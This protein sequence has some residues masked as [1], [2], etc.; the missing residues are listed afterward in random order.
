MV[1]VVVVIM[2]GIVVVV[3]VGIVVGI[4]VVVVVVVVMVV[5][6]VVVMRVMVVVVM[7]NGMVTAKALAQCQFGGQLSDGLALVQNCL[8]L[9]HQTFTQVQ[10]GGFGLVGHHAAPGARIWATA[11]TAGSRSVGHNGRRVAARVRLGW[12]RSAN[13]FGANAIVVLYAR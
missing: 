11:V 6:V 10:D 4:V 2:V 8:F 7:A 3:M 1:G 13:K 9:P 5:V 12:Y